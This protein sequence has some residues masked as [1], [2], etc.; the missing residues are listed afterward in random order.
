MADN[1][2]TGKVIGVAFDGTGYGT[3]DTISGGEVLVA[4]ELSFERAAH[5][6][7]IDLP[8]GD[9]AI[10]EPWR[11]ALSYCRF[12]GIDPPANLL[13]KNPPAHVRLVN[14]LLDRKV[15][16]VPTSSC[17]RLFDAVASLLGVRDVVTYEG[18][19]GMELEAIATDESQPVSL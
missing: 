9:Q 14:Q 7:P 12:A 2:I 15:Q 17:G 11:S 19:A 8:G 4:D 5:L 10:R 3:D 1:E 6:M 18:Q 16:T 13:E